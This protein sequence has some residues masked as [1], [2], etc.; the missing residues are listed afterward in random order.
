MRFGSRKAFFYGVSLSKNVFSR[1]KYF[2]KRLFGI[3]AE[4]YQNADYKN[5]ENRSIKQMFGA[6][7]TARL[8]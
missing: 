3:F 7:F 4:N 8:S 5:F 1:K 6:F 2:T